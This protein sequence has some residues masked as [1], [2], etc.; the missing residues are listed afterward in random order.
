MA[1]PAWVSGWLG[2]DHKF[3]HDEE[4]INWLRSRPDS[5]KKVMRAFPPSCVVKSDVSLLSADNCYGIVT[6]YMEDGMVTIRPN[7]NA[8]IR[9]VVDPEHLTVVGYWGGVTLEI[10]TSILK[11]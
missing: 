6:S 1:E 9:G 2:P 4:A 10:I 7:P 3:K 5:V 11:G 8:D